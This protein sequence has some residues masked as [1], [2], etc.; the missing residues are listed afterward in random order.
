MMN[1]VP[2]NPFTQ[3]KSLL[4]GQSYVELDK[5]VLVV[6]GADRLTWLNDILS[7]K[8]D[9]LAP[10][11]STE[12]LWLDVQGRVLRDF[13][14]VATNDALLLITF[15]QGFEDLINAFKRL[16]F[17]SQVEITVLEGYKVFGTLQ[18][19]LV[20]SSY[21]W[22][23]SWPKVSLGGYRYSKVSGSDWTY[24][25]SVAVSKPELLEASLESLESLRIAAFRPTG[26]N[27]IDEK[28][29]PHEL[30]WLTTAVHLD[31]GCY[32][33][34]ETVAKV[35]NLGAPPRRLVFLHLDGSGHLIPERGAK[36]LSSDQV[37]VITSVASHYEMG[38][39]ALGLVKRN[40][41]E[42][43]V[44]V[45]LADG[46]LVSAALEEIVPPDAGGVVDLGE[47]R[48]R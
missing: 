36:I 19:P 32:R 28:T 23:D 26:P 35:H 7:Q 8:L 15:G 43:T 46:S 5:K 27:E 24:F 18:K 38:P 9:V 22:K 16:I 44:Q 34:Q 29:I 17:R 1:Q 33:G 4:A 47:F 12:A 14:I 11:D 6:K 10:G 21:V 3:Q 30:D 40:L 39:I 45:E 41:K 25:E 31:K 42:L 13:H 37:G 2:G 48:K 20:E